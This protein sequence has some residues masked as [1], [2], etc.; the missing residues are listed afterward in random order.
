MMAGTGNTV[1][2]GRTATLWVENSEDGKPRIRQ[3]AT[4]ARDTCGKNNQRGR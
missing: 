1:D 2:T 3:Y 4:D